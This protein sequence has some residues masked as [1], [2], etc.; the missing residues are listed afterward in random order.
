[1]MDILKIIKMQKKNLEQLKK[2]LKIE[3]YKKV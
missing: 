3:N 2:K 1:M